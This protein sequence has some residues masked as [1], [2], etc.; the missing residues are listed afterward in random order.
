MAVINCNIYSPA[1]RCKTDVTVVLPFYSY[2]DITAGKRES[3]FP[4]GKK[5][6]VLWLLHGGNG[7][8]QDYINYT[9]VVR[10]AT[11]HMLAVVMPTG[12]NM[13]TDDHEGG[14]KMCTYI[15]EELPAMMR[16]IFPLSDKPE[17]NFIGGLSMGSNGAQKVAIRYPEQYSAVLAMSAGSFFVLPKLPEGQK[18]RFNTGMPMPPHKPNEMEENIEILKKDIAEGKKL[19]KFF[20]IWGEKDI[21]RLGQSNSVKFLEENGCDVYAEEVPG[22]GHE[23]DLWDQTLRKAFNELLPLKHDLVD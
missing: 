9:N 5:Y 2:E 12:Y 14:M 10:Y 21:A 11:E 16:D 23:W 22:F 15:G 18:V 20:M 6:Q 3:M 1:L 17:D 4:E 7:N 19:P 8:D 13:N